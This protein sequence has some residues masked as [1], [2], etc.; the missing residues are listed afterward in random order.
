VIFLS[1][2]VGS[3]EC[4]FWSLHQYILWLFYKFDIHVCSPTRPNPGGGGETCAETGIN[5]FFSKVL[6]TLTMKIVT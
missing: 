5:I 2:L 1:F 3:G 4:T 6:G